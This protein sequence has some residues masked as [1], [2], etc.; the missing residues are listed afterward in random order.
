MDVQHLKV[1]GAFPSATNCAIKQF[2]VAD[3]WSADTPAGNQV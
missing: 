3:R 1:L 2:P